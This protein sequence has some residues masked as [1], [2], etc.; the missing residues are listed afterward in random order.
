MTAAVEEIPRIAVVLTVVGG[1]VAYG[2]GLS[3]GKT[4]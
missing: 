2:Q 4:P 1:R 3:G